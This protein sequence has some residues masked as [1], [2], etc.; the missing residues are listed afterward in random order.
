MAIANA[1]VRHLV[2]K[3]KCKTLF[4]THYPII[5]SELERRFPG[6]VQNLH[7]GYNEET[8]I[9]GS[10]DITFLYQLTRG[11]TTESFGVECGRLAG[12]PE[13]ILQVAANKARDLRSVVES[14]TRKKKY[15]FVCHLRLCCLFILSSMKRL[16]DCAKLLQDCM[17]TGDK[18]MLD[19]LNAAIDAISTS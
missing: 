9:D 13:S 12:L 2:Q 4:V 1:V 17:R 6:Q 5:A 3:V 15:V 10:R 19:E 18:P 16:L 8:R 7:M 11:V 14:R